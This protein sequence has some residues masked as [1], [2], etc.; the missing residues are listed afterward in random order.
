MVN[1]LTDLLITEKRS[2]LFVGEGDFSFTV[3]F[4]ALR[5]FKKLDPHWRDSLF[6]GIVTTRCEPFLESE[7]SDA[8]VLSGAVFNC[9]ALGTEYAQS[10]LSSIE[11][12]MNSGITGG[13]REL[14]SI[15]R[16]MFDLIGRLSVFLEKGDHYPYRS[17]TLSIRYGIDARAIPPELIDGCQVIWFQCPWDENPPALIFNFLSNLAVQITCGVFVC[18]GI[19]THRDYFHRY[20]L[21]SL[22]SDVMNK[23]NFHGADSDLVNMILKFGYHH[24]GVRDIHEYIKHCHVTLIFERNVVI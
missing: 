9:I 15:S 13:G 12:Q 5:E 10:E 4:A 18:I 20:M 17:S 19:S 3:A 7:V 6:Q 23:Y 16:R 11:S 14:L 21:G 24:R 1:I 8:A 2:V 22:L